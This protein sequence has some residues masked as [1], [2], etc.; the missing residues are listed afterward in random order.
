MTHHHHHA[1]GE[2][3][4]LAI[5]VLTVSDSRTAA[6]DQSGE[7]L[8]NKIINAGHCL[9]A[10]TQS[11]DDIY[12]LRALLSTWIAEKSVQVIITTGGTG[13]TGRDRTPEAVLPLL[14]K[15]LTGFGELFRQLSFAHIGTATIQSRALAGIANGTLI[16]SLP[17]SPAACQLAWDDILA[18]QLD[19]RTSPCNFVQL[20]PRLLEQ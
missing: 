5:A 2:F 8:Q 12:Q 3:L 4:P 7:L 9:A 13:V 16:F 19:R 6:N 11:T 1:P 10:R 20:L 14:D 17:G 18:A 15:A